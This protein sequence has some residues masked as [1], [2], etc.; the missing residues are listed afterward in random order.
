MTSAVGRLDARGI[1][2]LDLTQPL[3]ELPA[4]AHP[5]LRVVLRAGKLPLGELVVAAGELPLPPSRLRELAAEAVA[6]TVG[7]RLLGGFFDP[8]L[9]ER[10]PSRPGVPAPAA[11]ACQ[12][13]EPL[14]RL[15]G[16]EPPAPVHSE[17]FSVVLCTRNRPAQLRGALEALG[18]LDPGPGEVIVVD[19]APADDATRQVVDAFPG[20]RYVGEPRPGLSVARNTGVRESVRDLIAF[21][22]DDARPVVSWLARLAAAFDDPQVG[23]VTGLVLPETLESEGA[24]A[25]EDAG[26][27]GQGYRRR[28]HDLAFF[29]GAKDRA[30]PVWRIGAG[31][32]MAVRRRVLDLVGGFDERLGAGAAGCSEDSELWYR[33]LAAGFTCRYEPAA[34][35]AHQH[36]ENI[37]E[38]RQQA[39]AYMRGHVTALAVQFAGHRHVGEL[40]RGLGRLPAFYARRLLRATVPSRPAD[41]LLPAEVAGYLSG[42]RQGLR[43]LRQDLPPTGRAVGRERTSALLAQNPFPHPYTEG[44]YFREKMR[45]IARV[46]P[47]DRIR[48]VLEVGGGQ[49]GLTSMLYPQA[50]V[51]SVDL[52][53]AFGS[54][55]A[56]RRLRQAFLA[57]DATRLPFVDGTFDAVTYF[58]VLEHIQ[59]D[60]LAVQ[61]ALRVLAPG[62]SLLVTSPNELWRFP[63]HRFL[64]P[65]TPRDTDVMAEW[66]HVRRGYTTAHL[67]QLVGRQVSRRATFINPVTVLAHDLAFSCLPSRVRRALITVLSPVVWTAYG[68]HRPHWP[69][70]ETAWW[71][72]LPL[73]PLDGR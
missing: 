31:A 41:P 66:G 10:R 65:L 56:N 4:Q 22:D 46:A 12:L 62:G 20:V 16:L 27:F 23:V 63:Y 50:D 38:A 29:E 34:E 32:A 73:G 55:A 2:Q 3:P 7:Q 33:V 52:E 19:N 18:A 11:S 40:R 28:D 54:A 36:R 39:K 58:D 37:A 45:A 51:V 9:P 68:L 53:P 61:E 71:W 26:G 14:A 48:R 72:R 70:T 35:V 47:D 24:R 57:A 42:V 13:V 43:V 59:D 15:A 17:A 69:G 60:G 49:S 8:P 5:E 21:T 44:F 67:E 30:V 64:A 25:F 6:A 1:L